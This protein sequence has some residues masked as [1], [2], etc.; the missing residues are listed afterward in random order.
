MGAEEVVTLLRVLP[1]LGNVYRNPSLAVDVELGPAVVSSDLGG[2]LVGRQRESDLEAGRDALGSSHGNEQGMEV[3]AVAFLRVAGIEHVAATPA[4]SGL[5]VAHGGE[6]VVVNGAGF[7]ERLRFVL[8]DF[9]RQISRQAGD[10]NEYVR[11]KI[12]LLFGWRE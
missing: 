8:G 12:L 3:S 1:G 9:G 10:R 6:D 11:L 7:V 4:R 5:V 2:V